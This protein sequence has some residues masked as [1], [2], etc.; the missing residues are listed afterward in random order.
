M[1]HSLRFKITCI[2]S[3]TVFLVVFLCWLSNEVLL[4]SFYQMEKVGSLC[5][6][7]YDINS[8]SDD[9]KYLS[10]KEYMHTIDMTETRNS[11]SVYIISS[12][13]F[14]YIYP[15]EMDM[16]KYQYS[17]TNKYS[18]ISYALQN[19]I[20]GTM[21]ENDSETTELIE[22]N[23][24][25]DVYKFYDSEVESSF[26]DLVGILDD[27][28]IVFIRTGCENIEESTLISSR[29]LAIIGVVV[30]IAGSLFMYFFCG[31]LVRP[32][33]ELSDISN[34]MSSLN[35]ETKYLGKR[36]DEIGRLGDS[37]NELSSKLEYTI[38]E[39]KTAN[40]E[41][42]KDIADKQAVDD[43]RKEFLS[44]V[45]HELKTPLALIMG[46]AEGLKDNINDDEE[47]RNFYC[48]VIIDEAEKMNNLVKKLLSLNEIEFGKNKLDMTRFNLTQM[49]K[50]VAY[51]M[52]VIKQ[53][54]G[55]KS[56][57]NIDRDYYVWGDAGLI[58]EV[59]TNYLSNAYNHCDDQKIIDISCVEKDN[60]II[61][62]SVFNT[63]KPIP[64]EELE[65]I[66]IKFYKV[67]KAR[68]REYGGNG[69][70]LSIVKAIM[71]QHKNG[72][73]VTNHTAG[74]EFWFELDSKSE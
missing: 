71:E 37:I 52:S 35:F 57:V 68:S 73:G 43:M 32:I 2:L 54:T 56:Y 51:N 9:A 5:Q 60:G 14:N 65:N 50:G 58:E 31:R 12:K 6:S 72:C 33:N 36:K 25:F 66:W 59:I 34:K 17:T 18:R 45:S 24:K 48:D 27:E 67:D 22:A 8:L 70:G 29:F 47:S 4:D 23:D 44:N 62:V 46:Y 26:I 55:I 49:I 74:V 39:L 61:R 28:N 40:I 21:F 7:Y 69:I 64:V 41:L 38:T 42:E 13:T 15:L 16:S 1:K 20:F 19:Y 10:E 30:I 63:G 53:E 3:L 11:V